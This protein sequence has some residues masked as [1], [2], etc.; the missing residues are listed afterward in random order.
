MEQMEQNQEAS[1]SN[2]VKVIGLW[3][4]QSQY[5]DIYTERKNVLIK[6]F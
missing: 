2:G 6:E 4:A 5:Y 3:V 1:Q